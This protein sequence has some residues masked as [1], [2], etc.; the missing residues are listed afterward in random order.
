MGGT[1]MRIWLSGPVSGRERRNADEFR[2]A[3]RF[4]WRE[5]PDASVFL[6]QWVVVPGTAWEQAMRECLGVLV[7]CDAIALMPDW[8]ESRG[9]RL[10]NLIA[11][12]VGIERIFIEREDM[13]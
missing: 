7:H 11:R 4:L 8:L 2:A 9:S 13:G 12:Q 3:Q 6:P 1:L 10:E 5:Y